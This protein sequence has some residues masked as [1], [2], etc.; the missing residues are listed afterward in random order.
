MP[1]KRREGAHNLLFL[2]PGSGE[3]RPGAAAGP[4]R[5]PGGLPGEAQEGVRP[6]GEGQV[7]ISTHSALNIVL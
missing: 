5:V 3:P 7:I 4:N 1:E 6:G 2:V